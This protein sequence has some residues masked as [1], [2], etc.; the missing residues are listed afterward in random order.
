MTAYYYGMSDDYA[1]DVC[2]YRG[3]GIDAETND[4]E[5][6]QWQVLA[7]RLMFVIVFEVRSH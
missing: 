2:R 1:E 4:S 6:T 3:Y 7:A 5:Y